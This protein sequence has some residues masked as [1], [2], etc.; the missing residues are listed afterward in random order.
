MSM[1]KVCG[2]YGAHSDYDVHHLSERI[3]ELESNLAK[4]ESLTSEAV[5]RE[6]ARWRASVRWAHDLIA[7]LVADEES[8]IDSFDSE[9]FLK[10]AAG[11][12][13]SDSSD[14]LAA[15]DAEVVRP[16]VE[17]LRAAEAALIISSPERTDAVL[18]KIRALLAPAPAAKGEG[19]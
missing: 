16:F 9:Q 13:A 1:C 6:A 10:E 15:H 3:S 8:N 7:R 14:W 12:L 11:L 5:A 19:L 4:S 2:Q 18:A 17:G